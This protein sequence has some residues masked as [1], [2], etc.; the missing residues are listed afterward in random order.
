MDRGPARVV[1]V[2]EASE[3]GIDH[4]YIITLKKGVG[5]DAHLEWLNDHVNTHS[6]SDKVQC[7]TTNKFKCETALGELTRNS[8]VESIVQDRRPVWHDP[9]EV[10]PDIQRQQTAF[11]LVQ[12]LPRAHARDLAVAA[13][14][15]HGEVAQ[16]SVATHD[17]APWGLQ[18][19]NQRRKL[20]NGSDPL[21]R[22]YT[23]RY[24]TPQQPKEVHAYVLD[25]GVMENHQEFSGRVI[26]TVNFTNAVDMDTDGHGTH[27][28]AI[29]G[30]TLVGVA[31]NVKI[32]SV[33]VL[34]GNS[35]SSEVTEGIEWAIDHVLEGPSIPSVINMSFAFR[36]GCV[37]AVD[38]AVNL[39]V[40]LGIHVVVAAGNNG[41]DAHDRSPAR[42][43]SSV[44]VGAST[45]E[46]KRR[47]TSNFG[48]CISIFAPG[49][50]ILSAGIGGIGDYVK[51]SGTSMAA[52]HVA[53]LMAH[54]IEMDGANSTPHALIGRICG[55]ATI[56]DRESADIPENTVYVVV[57]LD[58]DSSA[59]ITR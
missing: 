35:G 47:R 55:D 13:A 32:I 3:D 8:E 14:E 57:L 11:E 54:L 41:M 37:P 23:Y 10:P 27:V 44:T 28:A 34:G 24:S 12:E 59:L 56:L 15:V 39:A 2:V 6:Q 53:G 52:P 42:A 31:K 36:E 19:L 18:R 21:V 7:K 49:Q 4:K 58:D 48:S 9:Q 46:D 40:E 33:K 20:S 17:N 50:D 45:I 43:G 29:L 30:G 1:A 25:T 38:R 26:K 16:A 5:L 51:N 22:E